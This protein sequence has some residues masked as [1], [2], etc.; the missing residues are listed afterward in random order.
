MVY[1]LVNSLVTVFFV[2]SGLLHLNYSYRL[3]QLF[4]K[5]HDFKTS[6]ATS[7]LWIVA[8]LIY[9]ALYN[10]SDYEI[11][12]SVTITLL[13][14]FIV[15]ITLS[16]QLGNKK[17]SISSYKAF[18][19]NYVESKNNLRILRWDINRKSFHTI[20]VLL[21]FLIVRIGLAVDINAPLASVS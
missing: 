8:G 20:P 16:T 17:D 15:I 14:P 2:I 12:S 21:I 11:M 10:N 18:I 1:N 3:K 6:V 5:E 4:K 7:I 9:P 19:S 13:I